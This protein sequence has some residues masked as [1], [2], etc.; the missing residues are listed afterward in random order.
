ML[1]CVKPT[2]DNAQQC[3]LLRR[4]QR[5]LTCAHNLPAATLARAPCTPDQQSSEMP[6]RGS[7]A[8][9]SLERLKVPCR[10]VALPRTGKQDFAYLLYGLEFGDSVKTYIQEIL[11]RAFC[12]VP[13]LLT[14][15]IDDK[16]DP[17]AR[18]LVELPWSC[19]CKSARSQEK[20][21]PSSRCVR[22]G[23]CSQLVR[24]RL[25]G[26]GPRS[27]TARGR[28]VLQYPTNYMRYVQQLSAEPERPAISGG[29]RLV[30]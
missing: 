17:F 21:M 5:R 16:E 9:L 8:L 25:A 22:K 7:P 2:F 1:F 20:Q 27:G 26:H 18:W 14:T 13:F 10:K 3:T 6:C 23:A 24:S 15:G 4:G 12:S 28:L 11:T 30:T 19:H 29:A